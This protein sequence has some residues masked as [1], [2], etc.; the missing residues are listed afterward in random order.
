MQLEFSLLIFR[1]R[2]PRYKSCTLQS[3]PALA[4]LLSPVYLEIPS[5]SVD[6][7]NALVNVDTSRVE[8]DDVVDVLVKVDTSCVETDDVIGEVVDDVVVVVDV[9]VF[10]SIYGQEIWKAVV[11]IP[12]SDAEWNN[13][14][15]FKSFKIFPSP[16]CSFFF[17]YL[18]EL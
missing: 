13:A 10:L 7:G 5:E 15:F 16:R 4:S 8:A 11:P 2:C 17:F 6:V 9:V 3:L 18:N 12:L 1:A 14:A